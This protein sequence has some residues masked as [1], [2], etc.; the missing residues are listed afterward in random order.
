MNQIYRAL[1]AVLLAILLL[2]MVV[3]C[4]DKDPDRSEL[5]NRDLKQKPDY[6]MEA[7][8]DGSYFRDFLLYFADTFPGREHMLDDYAILDPSFELTETEPT[9]VPDTETVTEAPTE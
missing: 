8:L 1:C 5:E 3:T 4:F 6:S 9:Q 7:L 2:V